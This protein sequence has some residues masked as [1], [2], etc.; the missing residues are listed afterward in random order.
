M[1]ATQLKCDYIADYNLWQNDLEEYLREIFGKNQRF[2]VT[3]SPRSATR[4]LVASRTE[5]R[6]LTGT[7]KVSR[8]NYLMKIPRR[9]SKVRS[10]ET[11]SGRCRYRGRATGQADS[12]AFARVRKRARS[13]RSTTEF[14]TEDSDDDVPGDQ[15]YLLPFSF[16]HRWTTVQRICWTSEFCLE[17]PL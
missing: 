6:R 2:E 3:A 4:H 11:R 8:N 16:V 9:L 5:P 14:G 15:V 7:T 1:S 12:Q 17:F 10:Q 13:R